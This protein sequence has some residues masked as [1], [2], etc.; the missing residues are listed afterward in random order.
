MQNEQTFFNDFPIISV[1]Q[2]KQKIQFLLKGADYNEQCVWKSYEQININPFYNAETTADKYFFS[3]KNSEILL[4]VENSEDFIKNTD[5]QFFICN[6]FPNFDFFSLI[7]K[8][9]AHKLFFVPIT[10]SK[11]IEIIEKQSFRK[12]LF[13][14]DPI[15]NLSKTGNF[16]K[17]KQEDFSQWQ[18]LFQKQQAIFVDA[19]F[20]AE[21][22]ATKIQQIAYV[23]G[24]LSEYFNL[25]KTI[26]NQPVKI[27]VLFGQNPDF[28]L[29][30]A[31]VRAFRWL[32]NSVFSSFQN[33]DLQIITQ[34]SSRYISL[35][36]EQILGNELRHKWALQSGVFAGSDYVIPNSLFYETDNKKYIEFLNKTIKKSS[37]KNVNGSFFLN[38]ITFQIIQQSLALWKEI[39]VAGG[40]LSQ[41]KKHIIQRKVKEKAHLSQVDFDTKYNIKSVDLQQNTAKWF[42]RKNPKKLLIEPILPQR[43]SQKEELKIFNKNTQSLV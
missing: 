13:G 7:E 12:C 14:F 32:F 24:I 26:D 20:F 25:L 15:G 41:L 34:P 37:E 29:E 35:F 33:I 5:F 1:K 17:N 9:N 22:G 43:L 2:W 4:P 3:D 8:N 36:S 31:K 40:Y 38:T 6:E 21:A 10:S 18:T 39:Q 19:S 30:I 28:Y 27:F 11:N 23:F 16:F 42:L